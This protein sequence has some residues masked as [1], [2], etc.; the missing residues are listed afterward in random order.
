MF[1]G[2]ITGERAVQKVPNLVMSYWFWRKLQCLWYLHTA[3]AASKSY[4][5][6]V[7][8]QDRQSLEEKVRGTV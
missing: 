8:M 3:A 4:Q 1:P 6:P 5:S 2:I 7:N